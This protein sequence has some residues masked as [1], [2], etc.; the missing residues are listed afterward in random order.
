MVVVSR[1][2]NGRVYPAANAYLEWINSPFVLGRIRAELDLECPDQ[3][4]EH[5]IQLT[6]GELITDAHTCAYHG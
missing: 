4:E 3:A 2:I 6:T 5:G 1:R